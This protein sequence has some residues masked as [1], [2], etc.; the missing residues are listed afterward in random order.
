MAKQL[1]IK[2][3]FEW[4]KLKGDDRNV[5][6]WIDDSNGKYKIIRFKYNLFKRLLIWIRLRIGRPYKEKYIMSIDPYQISDSKTPPSDIEYN[7]MCG[8]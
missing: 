6:K 8:G 7:K 1:I 5:I 4:A 3:Y 2:G